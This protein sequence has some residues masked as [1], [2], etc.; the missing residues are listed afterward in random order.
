[1]VTLTKHERWLL[2]TGTVL[3]GSCAGYGIYNR[4]W[5]AHAEAAIHETVAAAAKGQSPK[6]ILASVDTAAFISDFALPYEIVGADNFLGG[7][8]L[9]DLMSPGVYV[10]TL[11][12]TNGHEYE[13]E[14]L[15]GQDGIWQVTISLRP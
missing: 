11:H 4:V 9:I 14:A 7:T 13:A 2:I 15:R 6:G 3:L 12:F 8:S 1:M 5:W 10:S